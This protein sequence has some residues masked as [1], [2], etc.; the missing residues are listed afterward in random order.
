MNEQDLALA[1]KKQRLVL[2]SAALRVHLG[3]EAGGLKPAFAS[4]DQI[5]EGAAWLREHLHLLAV[6]G[7]AI[8]LIR[9]R[10]AFRWGRRGYLLWQALRKLRTRFVSP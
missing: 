9:P 6:A 8:A 5:R 3:R 4:A 1:L 7:A 2:R 10:A